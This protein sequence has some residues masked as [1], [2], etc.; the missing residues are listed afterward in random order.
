LSWPYKYPTGT[1]VVADEIVAPRKQ[2]ISDYS[3][4]K[5][6]LRPDG[7]LAYLIMEAK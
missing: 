4:L 6:V 3:I 2:V 1:I 7:S 5:E